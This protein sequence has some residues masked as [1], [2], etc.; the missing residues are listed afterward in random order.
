MSRQKVSK[1]DT[2]TNIHG[3]P[4][5][6]IQSR[7]FTPNTAAETVEA[8]TA[9]TSPEQQ[10]IA[11]QPNTGLN[12]NNIKLFA[13]E[14]T[15]PPAPTINRF[16]QP[17]LTIGQPGDRY[18]QEADRVASQVVQQ[19]NSPLQAQI[20]E[21]KDCHAKIDH[22]N[23]VQR[24]PIKIS[25]LNL[26]VSTMQR[27]DM[28]DTGAVSTDIENQIQQAKG[29]GQPLS[30]KIRQPMEQAMQADF[31][32][33]KIHAGSQADTL[34]RSIQAKAFTTGQ[35]I[36]FK[37]D[38]YNPGSE[39]GQELIA[40]ELTHVVQQN[41]GS[42]QRNIDDLATEATKEVTK[43]PKDV[44]WGQEHGDKAVIQ[45]I[46]QGIA[47]GSAAFMN[48]W[49]GAFYLCWKA[50]LLP[51]KIIEKLYK[52]VEDF[53]EILEQ[54]D[55]PPQQNL[56]EKSVFVNAPIRKLIS[57]DDERA[58]DATNPAGVK[59][60]D[61]ILFEE[62]KGDLSHVAVATDVNEVVHLWTVTTTLYDGF[63]Q[64]STQELIDRYSCLKA[65]VSYD[66]KD[67]TGTE[68]NHNA[69]YKSRFEQKR[70]SIFVYACTPP[71][72][73]RPEELSNISKQVMTETK[74]E[75][76][77]TYNL[78][79]SQLTKQSNGCCY[80]TTACAMAQGLADDCYELTTLRSFRDSY[81]SN[82]KH[83]SDLIKTYY[84]Y[85]PAIVE[86]INKRIDSQGIYEYLYSVIQ[87]CVQQI[88]QKQY[89]TALKTY[90]DMVL[91]LRADYSP[92]I[93]LPNFLAEEELEEELEA[94]ESGD[95]DE[96]NGG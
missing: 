21:K 43:D 35:D 93:P 88:Q 41:Q 92:H 33:V 23:L 55:L 11:Q 39:S 14:T 56:A 45:T 46:N 1:T 57:F 44:F 7:P 18:E 90:V 73:T 32:N 25:P 13:A 31:S 20:Q 66:K 84:Q 51:K 50:D 77:T 36:F 48:C 12:F 78:D 9:E 30:N 6:Q 95:D 4:S 53:R 89:A 24:Q 16:I 85:S 17:K 81:M 60:G 28:V 42:I 58:L 79:D 19:I 10:E 38:A 65:G 22:H 76:K 72:I 3:A 62:V 27:T 83:G 96:Q 2:N 26:P 49:D 74:K 59:A 52:D 86:A 61:F 82:L 34:S 8:P 64:L 80:I 70:N 40:H 37:K 91:Q 75:I 5:P 69:S 71:W 94:A 67:D 63:Q 29:N 47:E 87:G 15:P 54:N 68:K